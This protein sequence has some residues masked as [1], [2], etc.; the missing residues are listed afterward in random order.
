ML[1]NRGAVTSSDFHDSAS[2]GG[3]AHEEHEVPDVLE[4][5]E[6]NRDAL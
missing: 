4:H 5:I 6:G 3:D 2:K 1:C